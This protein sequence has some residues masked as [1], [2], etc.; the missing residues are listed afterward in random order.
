MD[1]TLR[2]WE[3]TRVARE[4]RQIACNNGRCKEMTEDNVTSREDQEGYRDEE[5][6]GRGKSGADT[7]DDKIS[8]IGAL[9]GEGE[10]AGHGD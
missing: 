4:G 9:A 2:G 3:S 8:S 7:K 5:P 6:T 1:T 10:A